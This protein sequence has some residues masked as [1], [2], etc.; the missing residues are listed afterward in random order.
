MDDHVRAVQKRIRAVQREHPRGQRRYP[1]DLRAE[2]VSVVRAGQAAGRSMRRLARALGV[3]APT[4]TTWVHA[5]SR[6]ALR[7]VTIAP[8]AMPALS[9]P[10]RPVLVTPHGVRVEGLDVAGVVTVL[11]ALA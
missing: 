3:S 4:L 5:P 1:A 11:R 2:I 6:G 7:P 8:D 10:S 9:P